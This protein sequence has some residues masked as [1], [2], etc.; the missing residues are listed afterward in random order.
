MIHDAGI[1]LGLNIGSAVG[2]GRVGSVQLIVC[3]ALG[4]TAQR[5]GLLDIRVDLAVDFLLIDQR[6]EAEAL[7][8]VKAQCRGDVR[9]SLDGDDIHGILNTDAQRRDAAVGL[10]VPVPAGCAVFEIEGRVVL[11]VRQCHAGRIERR[12]VG[13]DNLEGRSGL[14]GRIRRAVQRPVCGLLAAAADHGDH[15]AGGLILNGQRNLRLRRETHALV[16][17][18]AAR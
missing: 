16:V 2:D 8:I 1:E 9:Q 15:I 6:C 4:Q 13:G 14:S 3:N 7:E 12:R 18:T 17:D 11:G 5:Q 10:A